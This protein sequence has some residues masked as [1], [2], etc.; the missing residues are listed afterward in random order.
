MSGE[1]TTHFSHF[2]WPGETTYIP[3]RT[4]RAGRWE[5]TLPA[6]PTESDTRPLVTLGVALFHAGY[7]WEAHEVWECR[8]NAVGRTGPE[9]DLLRGLIH[10]TA[11][12]VK[13]REE[14]LAGVRHHLAR[15]AEL[16]RGA[17]ALPTAGLGAAGDLDVA[18]AVVA[19]EGLEPEALVRQGA[20]HSGL[21]PVPVLGLRLRHAG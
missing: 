21:R 1:S 15:A 18:A 14:C 12:G 11:G 2:G 7:Y 13:A 20:T 16:L 9:A 3:G 19:I 5:P 8:W 4:P 17:A 10:L 6:S